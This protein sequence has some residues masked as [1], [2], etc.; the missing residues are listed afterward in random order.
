MNT[1]VHHNTVFKIIADLIGFS[2]LETSLGT[3]ISEYW[4]RS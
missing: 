1:I 2:V 3:H 4:G